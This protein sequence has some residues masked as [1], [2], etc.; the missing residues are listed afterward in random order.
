MQRPS[1]SGELRRSIARFGRGWLGA[2]TKPSTGSPGYWSRLASLIAPGG[3]IYRDAHYL[4]ADVELDARIAKRF[5]PWP[6]R[7]STP[8]RA[9]VFTGYFPINTFGSVYYEAGVFFDV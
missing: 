8:A 3:W 7:L 1:M 5:V 2:V 9:Q 6:L 4:V